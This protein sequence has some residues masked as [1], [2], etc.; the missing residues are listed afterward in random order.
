MKIDHIKVSRFNVAEL[1]K[2]INKRTE[3]RNVHSIFYEP[4]SLVSGVLE[5]KTTDIQ[6]CVMKVEKPFKRESKKSKYR[7]V[8]WDKS[9]NKWRARIMVNGK[10]ISLGV[11]DDEKEAAKAYDIKALWHLA[12][13]AKTNFKW[14]LDCDDANTWK[15]HI[16]KG[17]K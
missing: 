13:L 10:R 12:F 1:V 14:Y 4:T 17:N 7:G 3:G 2:E 9:L 6:H 5:I 8:S 16:E 11:Y 15:M